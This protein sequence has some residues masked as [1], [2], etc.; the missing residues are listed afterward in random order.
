MNKVIN[1]GASNRLSSLFCLKIWQAQVYS[2]W[3]VDCSKKQQGLD[4][5][6]MMP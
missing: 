1:I 4:K 5:T 2:G 6:Y 3:K